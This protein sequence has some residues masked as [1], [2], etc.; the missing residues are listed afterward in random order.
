GRQAAI[1]RGR[2]SIPTPHSSVRGHPR[3]PRF[4]E[5]SRRRRLDIFIRGAELRPVIGREVV[6]GERVLLGVLEQPGDLGQRFA[7]PLER[8]AD[9]LACLL[10]VVGAEGRAEKGGELSVLLTASVAERL[11]QEVD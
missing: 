9:E 11:A 7:E 10:S 2:A 8:L 5:R 4:Y 1:L 3:P 6:E